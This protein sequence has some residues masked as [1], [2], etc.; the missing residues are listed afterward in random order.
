M[1]ASAAIGGGATATGDISPWMRVLLF[2]VGW[3]LVLIGVAGLVLPGIQGI[4]T[5]AVGLALLSVVSG[6]IHRWIQRGLQRWP[7]LLEKM[8]TFR[9]K[10]RRRLGRNL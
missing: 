5:I 6:A 8:E 2:S 7:S 1:Q 3:I 10:I 9:S 4:L